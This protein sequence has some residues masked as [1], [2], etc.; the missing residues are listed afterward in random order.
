MRFLKIG[1]GEIMRN[2]STVDTIEV[3]N[4]RF[5]FIVSILTRKK[6]YAIL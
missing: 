2:I 4:C 6:E 3:I 1:I 5:L